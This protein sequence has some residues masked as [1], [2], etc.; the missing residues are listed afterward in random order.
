MK[1]SPVSCFKGHIQYFIS[2]D[3]LYI[4]CLIGFSLQPYELGEINRLIQRRQWPPTPVFLPRESLGQRRLVGCCP[5]GR[6]E[7]DTTEATYLS[8]GLSRARAKMQF[9]EY[10][11]LAECT[12]ILEHSPWSSLFLQN[13]KCKFFFP[14]LISFPAKQNAAGEKKEREWIPS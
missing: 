1:E 3:V 5:R 4:V 10:F 11:T 8:N 6:T 2:S 9:Q 14:S 12:L 7:S 13:H